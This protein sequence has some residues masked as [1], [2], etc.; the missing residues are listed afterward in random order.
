M[1]T[2]RA[3]WVLLTGATLLFRSVNAAGGEH[4]L[5]L[6]QL[7][8]RVD[9]S[10]L[11]ELRITVTDRNGMIVT[12]ENRVISLEAEA[13]THDPTLLVAEIDES[14]PAFKFVN[15]TTLPANLSG[16]ELSVSRAGEFPETAVVAISSNTILP[17]GGTIT[18]GGSPAGFSDRNEY[19]APELFTSI[20]SQVGIVQVRDTMGELV[21]EVIL[22]IPNIGRMGRWSGP[23]LGSTVVSNTWQRT[24]FGNHYRRDDW[25]SRQAT[26]NG[27]NSDLHLPFPASKRHLAVVP[28][29]VHLDHGQWTG[30]VRLPEA[31]N[32]VHIIARGPDGLVAESGPI[33]VKAEKRLRIDA[34]AP[35]LLESQ[36]GTTTTA[37]VHL[38]SPVEM[39]LPVDLEVSD[40]TQL[41]VT[42]SHLLLPP[43]ATEGSVQ[44]ES[45]DD[46]VAD[47]TRRLTIRAVSPLTEPAE[48]VILQTDDE[49]G[50]LYLDLVP[51]FFAPDSAGRTFV[52][53]RG[54]AGFGRVSLDQPTE[55]PVVVSLE[56]SLPGLVG[57]P[58][59]VVIE[60]GRVSAEFLLRLL[61]ND[62]SD[63]PRPWFRITARTGDWPP[64]E[65][66]SPLWDNEPAP[67]SLELPVALIEGTSATGRIRINPVSTRPVVVSLIPDTDRM[68]VPS[69]VVIPTGISSVLFEMSVPD[70]N[71]ASPTALARIEARAAGEYL[72]HADVHVLDE[73]PKTE[74]LRITELPYLLF[75]DQP[76]SMVIEAVDA[77]GLRQNENLEFQLTLDQNWGNARLNVGN[78]IL[79]LTNGLWAGQLRITGEAYEATVTASAAHLVGSRYLTVVNGRTENMK[80]VDIALVPEKSTLLVTARENANVE[81]GRLVEMDLESGA[82]IRELSLAAEPQWLAVTTDGSTAYIARLSGGIDRVDLRSWT[83]TSFAETMAE[84][85]YYSILPL[86]GAVSEL[87]AVATSVDGYPRLRRFH[88]GQLIYEKALETPGYLVGGRLAGEV[89]LTA[90][91]QISRLRLEETNVVIEVSAPLDS[92]WDDRYHHAVLVNGR[93]HRFTGQILD[94]DSLGVIT[95]LST[96]AGIYAPDLSSSLVYFASFAATRLSVVDPANQNAW[97]GPRLP[98]SSEWRRMFRWG[99]RGVV[100]LDGAGSITTLETS[101]V[102]EGLS[103]LAIQ[104]T[105]PADVEPDQDFS[106]TFGITNRGPDT[107]TSVT[108]KINPGLFS[109]ERGWFDTL[110][111]G[112]IAPG[113]QW[114]LKHT[115]PPFGNGL[116]KR[117][118]EVMTLSTDPD[119]S[120]NKRDHE[121]NVAYRP[122]SGLRKIRLP[123]TQL[124]FSSATGRLYGSICTAVGADIDGV[125]I[126]NPADGVIETVLATSAAPGRLDVS[127]DG[128]FL[129]VAVEGGSVER[130]D[131]TNK[132]RDLVIKPEPDARVI[133]VACVPGEPRSVI[134]STLNQLSVFDDAVRRPEWNRFWGE[135]YAGCLA[136]STSK[137][138]VYW[139]GP[140]ALA[141]YSL[142]ASGLHLLHDTTGLPD[143]PGSIDFTPTDTHLYFEDGRRLDLARRTLTYFSPL[144]LATLPDA[145]RPEVVFGAFPDFVEIDASTGRILTREALRLPLE[146]TFELTRWALDSFAFL[147]RGELVLY[148]DLK[149]GITSPGDLAVTVSATNRLFRGEPSS[150][151]I[152]VS[153]AWNYGNT[154]VTL[155]IS[156]SG[157]QEVLFEDWP[158]KRFDNYYEI[159]LGEL[160][161]HET[162]IIR[163]NGLASSDWQVVLD[164]RVFSPFRDVD[165]SNNTCNLTV[166]TR[167]RSSDLEVQVIEVPEEALA[168]ELIP[169]RLRLVNHGPDAALDPF[170]DWRRVEGLEWI[171]TTYDP[172]AEDGRHLIEAG[173]ESEVTVFFRTI[174]PGVS[175]LEW[176]VFAS[177]DSNPFNNRVSHLLSVP[178][179]GTGGIAQELRL[180]DGEVQWNE[181]RQ[182]LAVLAGSER[183]RILLL[184]RVTFRPAASHLLPGAVQHWQITEEGRYIWAAIGQTNAVR[185]DLDSGQVDRSFVTHPDAADALA[186]ASPP[187][188]PDRLVVGLRFFREQRTVLRTFERGE[189]VGPDLEL[190]TYGAIQLLFLDETRLMVGSPDLLREV[191]LSSSGLS[192]TTNLDWI[193][194][195]AAF[196][197]AADKIV[198]ASGQVVE[199]AT[200]KPVERPLSRSVADPVTA[201]IY[202]IPFSASLSA[203]LDAESADRLEPIWHASIPDV[204]VFNPAALLPLGSSGLLLRGTRHWIIETPGLVRP[205]VDL[206]LSLPAQSIRNY[207]IATNL[208]TVEIAN[209]SSWNASGVTLS[210]TLPRGLDLVGV[211][212]PAVLADLDA[213][214]NFVIRAPGIVTGT[215]QP[216]HLRVT[217]SSPGTYRLA[218][219]AV[220]DQ[221]EQSVDDNAVELLIEAHEYPTLIADPD[222]ILFESLGSQN[223]APFRLTEPALHGLYVS[224]TMTFLTANPLEFAKLRFP[225][226]FRAGETLAWGRFVVRQDTIPEGV[227]TGRILLEG[228]QGMP[229]VF[230]NLSFSLIDD[231]PPQVAWVSQPF[232]E[233]NAGI[234]T[235]WAVGRLAEPCPY[236]IEWTIHPLP[237]STAGEDDYQLTVR[238]ARL[239]AGQTEISIP[240]GIVGD[241]TREPNEVVNLVV[242]D[243]AG[244][245]TTALVQQEI[246]DDDADTVLP[247]PQLL[248]LEFSPARRRVVFSTTPGLTYSLE[249]SASLSGADWTEVGSRL[250]SSAAETGF[251]DDN[252]SA[253]A[254]AFY[255]LRCE[256]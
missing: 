169:V 137:G 206:R 139:A 33:S 9:V 134:I 103:D 220:S 198:F 191:S 22:V 115:Q 28:A 249:R 38:S 27:L 143:F 239:E 31:E 229:M 108:L 192:E 119:D 149:T 97:H 79:R 132:S 73:T 69:P 255:R 188:N 174:L 106:L 52:E 78:Q 125:A 111:I 25:V 189:R 104:V 204:V 130:W 158:V 234:S 13:A 68:I 117:T 126:V 80:A 67:V 164:A 87:M 166:E 181:A 11:F 136:V 248:R 48:T 147:T 180:P 210:G 57:I 128:R 209:Q 15:S 47:G 183:R 12:Q 60:T 99:R 208:V 50:R 250:K 216:V 153:N 77:S 7:P 225:L 217:T 35:V 75:S 240:I 156:I 170:L 85:G 161:A 155:Q 163:A 222:L 81:K 171:S 152:V 116:I 44:V 39:E 84:S 179:V 221:F 232:R 141:E 214:G 197:S 144:M 205:A 23:T 49:V 177:G 105:G 224:L 1:C 165:L 100:L 3:V 131:L 194:R 133:D 233:G 140:L 124:T 98:F 58:R 157:Q 148:K 230:K 242:E 129:Y 146:P 187:Q 114:E 193:S 26:Q 145:D 200:G 184:D 17:P 173:A 112:S 21:D 46:A 203:V 107:A 241:R 56:S 223:S 151:E 82:M 252:S 36:P 19:P 96:G 55:G 5:L 253:G 199:L 186:I 18:W 190:S 74:A 219:S 45:L 61:D 135:G 66:E 29:A 113:E 110:E 20:R 120:N 185:L 72:T 138:I 8:E 231:D 238:R 172:V 244:G 237:D 89:F 86:A 14:K 59:S 34:V 70:D 123:A 101:L 243:V 227:Q 94:P 254:E 4:Q 2:R 16:W 218:L 6:G 24:G 245:I 91:N 43:G 71:D 54:F 150:F 236:P 176:Q 42:P 202:S 178:Q 109:W 159:A 51:E 30:M 182:Q 62:F 168:G 102:R 162:V 251:I 228:P 65:V 246:L 235:A 40:P 41:R 142:D 95:N 32:A 93:L 127:S 207:V 175:V 211:L 196:S 83:V 122:V 167:E 37:T 121:I 201:R 212:E 92:A 226:V 215:P 90:G 53:G 64:A 154:N 88:G 256:Q 247:H 195:S 160:S 118:V 63:I 213:T 76:V 10:E